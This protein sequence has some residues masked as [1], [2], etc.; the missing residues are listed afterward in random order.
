MRL[1]YPVELREMTEAEG[2]GWLVTFPDWGG[3]VTDGEDRAAALAN[4]ADC[5]ETMIDYCL[6]RGEDIPSPGVGYGQ[7]LVVPD[8]DLATKAALWR[9]F[10]ASGPTTYEL[11]TRLGIST[12][13]LQP[14]LFHPRARP[15]SS[16]IG[17]AAALG[18]RV[19]VELEDA[20]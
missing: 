5:L 16:M 14:R 3:A 9:A 4:A 15:R 1:A 8:S 11:A 19:V 6:R 12:D 13:Q 17:A 7:P 10:H 2:G 18:K 20:A